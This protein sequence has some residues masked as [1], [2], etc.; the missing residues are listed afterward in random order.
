MKA[1]WER[2]HGA[3][4]GGSTCS[5]RGT[6]IVSTKV[7]PSGK[8]LTTSSVNTIKTTTGLAFVVAVKNSGCAQEVGLKVRLTIQQSPNPI[9]K[10]ATIA[11][12]NP[13]DE[14]TVEFKNLGLPPLDQ[15]TNLTVEV[16]PVPHEQILSNN[17]ASYSV[18]F[19]VG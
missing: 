14:M 9:K 16:D 4:T 5:P 19:S 3:A 18:Q 7:L 12:L 8:T 13:G 17:T 11:L 10:E 1:V 15:R 2:I 6:A